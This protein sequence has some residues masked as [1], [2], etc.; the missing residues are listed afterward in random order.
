MTAKPNKTNTDKQNH[1]QPKR[2]TRWTCAERAT[3][4]ANTVSAASEHYLGVIG[5]EA[6][7][8]AGRWHG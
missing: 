8:R 7:A 2:S 6:V 5:S 3:G 1:K 4:V